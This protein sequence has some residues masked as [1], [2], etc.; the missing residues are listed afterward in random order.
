LNEKIFSAKAW[1]ETVLTA[2]RRSAAYQVSLTQTVENGKMFAGGLILYENMVEYRRRPNFHPFPR[3]QET[4][5][6]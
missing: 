2:A 1:D 3:I 6:T 5:K 4:T